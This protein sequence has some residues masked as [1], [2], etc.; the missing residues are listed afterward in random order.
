MTLRAKIIIGT[1]AASIFA[2][3]GFLVFAYYQVTQVTVPNAYA[4]W[5]TADLVIQHLEKNAGVW[6]KSWDDLRTTSGHAY[7]GTASTNLDGTLTV[8]FRARESIEE[9]QERVEIDWKADPLEL[10]KT[11]SGKSPPFRVIWLKNGRSTHYS[12]KEPNQMILEYLKS[13]EDEKVAPGTQSTT[14]CGTSTS[15]PQL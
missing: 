1:V 9:L 7:K 13:K 12:G 10:L 5:W 8:E 4:V 11:E 2:I 14:N 3:V 6:P 15:N